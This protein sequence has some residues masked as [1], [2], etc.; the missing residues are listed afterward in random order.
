[1]WLFSKQH[2]IEHLASK[3]KTPLIIFDLLLFYFLFG[4]A[5]LRRFYPRYYKMGLALREQEKH[6]LHM[7]RRDRDRFSGDECANIKALAAELHQARKS[8]DPK[9]LEKAYKKLQEDEL[10][11]IP[12]RKQSAAKEYVEIFI[13]A[14]ALAFG[15]RGLFLQPFKIP[16]GSMEPTLFGI[17]FTSVDEMPQLN[18]VKRFFQYLHYSRRYTD[19][20]IKE[21]GYLEAFGPAKSFPLFPAT[22][23]Q[24][25][26]VKYRLPGD[27]LNVAEYCRKIDAQTLAAMQRGR[28]VAVY[29]EK[30][31]VLAQGHLKLGDHLFVDR[32]HYYFK[33]PHR[34]DITVF[35]TDGIEDMGGGGLGGRYYIKRLVGLPG[36]QLRIIDRR[37]YVKTTESVE[38]ELVDED[39][40]VGFARIYSSQGGYHGYTHH[41]SSQ[42]L[43]SDIDVFTVPENHYFMLGD[44]SRNS[45]D[46]RFWGT[47]PRENL[48]GRAFFV[49]WPF[50]RRWGFADRVEPL[51]FSTPSRAL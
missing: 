36:D 43:N 39:F 45:K 6:L 28:R 23:V 1:M 26:G 17:H 50:S 8:K 27:P 41:P 14:L 15:V 49:W 4:H 2:P 10:P 34:G 42:Y 25:G 44:N 19:V 21:S 48:V 5:L 32:T 13:V 51:D 40:D 18:P 46:S 9:E 35:I 30:G 22:M 16:T 24:I 33:E 47:V 37:L 3:M 12:R 38:Y 29:Y 20:V 11:Q 31:E 7:L